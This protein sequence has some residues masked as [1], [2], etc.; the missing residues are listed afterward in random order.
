M[1]VFIQILVNM[2]NSS[3]QVLGVP[4]ISANIYWKSRNLPNTGIHNYSTDL[5]LFLRHQV[6]VTLIRYRIHY[7]AIQD[8]FCQCPRPY[9]ST[10]QSPDRYPVVYWAICISVTTNVSARVFLL[11]DIRCIPIPHL[12][13]RAGSW[14]VLIKPRVSLSFF[15]RV[16]PVIVKIQIRTLRGAVV[17]RMS[18]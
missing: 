16:G 2:F 5:L 18:P 11:F 7:Q 8:V 3:G 15:P 4:Y 13:Y 10:I 14:S 6:A 17:K 9:I 1:K 12:I